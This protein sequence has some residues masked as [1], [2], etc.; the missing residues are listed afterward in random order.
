MVGERNGFR[1]EGGRAGPRGNERLGRVL[2]R[3]DAIDNDQPLDFILITGDV[4][5]AGRSAEWAEFL[6]ALTEHPR[7]AK[8][9]LI[10]PGN[11]DVNV[12]DRANPARLDLPTNPGRRLRQLRALS[13]METVQG[14]KA[15]LIDPVTQR[16]GD[17]LSCALD[18]Y[19]SR[20]A[21]FADA[22]PCAYRPDWH[23]CGPMHF[24]W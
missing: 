13:A 18:T 20:I 10:L 3:L 7:L 1:I 24:R 19:R 11:H 23:N 14:N 21:A 5:D 15:R 9:T 4:S 17:T 6:S 12:V 8:R 16:L 2:A 22:G